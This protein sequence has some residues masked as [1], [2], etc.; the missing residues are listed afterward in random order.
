MI[1]TEND[2]WMELIWVLQR[3]ADTLETLKDN[4]ITMKV[5]EE[6]ARANLNLEDY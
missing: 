5:P 1:D 3:I 2:A 6:W 4:K